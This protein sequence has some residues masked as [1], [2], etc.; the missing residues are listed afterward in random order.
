M[1]I[2]EKGDDNLKEQKKAKQIRM[3]DQQILVVDHVPN[4]AKSDL[5]KGKIEDYF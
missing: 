1:L 2:Y 4:F 3:Q 5:M